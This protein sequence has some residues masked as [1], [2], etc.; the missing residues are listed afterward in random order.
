MGM[1]RLQTLYVIVLRT[2]DINAYLSC[3]QLISKAAAE[4]KLPTE[5]GARPCRGDVSC[6]QNLQGLTG[7]I[8]SISKP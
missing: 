4:Y 7:Y 6:G 8:R 3:D 5:K 1:F 2:S